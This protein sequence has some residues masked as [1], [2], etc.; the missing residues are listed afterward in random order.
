M[1]GE[2]A[3]CWPPKLGDKVYFHTLEGIQCG[4]LREVRQ[5]LLW[6]NYILDD[7]RFLQDHDFVMCPEFAPWRDPA[8]VTEAELNQVES[9]IKPK[10][11]AGESM[12]SDPETWAEFLQLVVF[13]HQ[14][15]R[16]HEDP[17]PEPDSSDTREDPP[18]M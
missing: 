12:I 4:V 10:L 1:K 3:P 16:S 5:G 8:T 14:K 2:S 6:K 7:G 17:E 11:D 15:T 9:R 18:I 13:Q